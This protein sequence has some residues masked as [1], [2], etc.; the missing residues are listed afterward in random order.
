MGLGRRVCEEQVC[1]GRERVCLDREP[2]KEPQR[3]WCSK[4]VKNDHQLLYYH[5]I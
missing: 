5:T 2:V 1:S 3:R 4:F